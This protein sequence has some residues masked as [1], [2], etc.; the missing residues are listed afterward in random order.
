M[1]KINQGHLTIFCIV[2]VWLGVMDYNPSYN[3]SSWENKHSIH[4]YVTIIWPLITLSLRYFN[5]KF[6][7]LKVES[8]LAKYLHS[9]LVTYFERIK[10]KNLPL[11][12]VHFTK[13]SIT[14]L[15]MPVSYFVSCL[16]WRIHS[17][18][19]SFVVHIWWPNKGCK[20][21][22]KGVFDFVTL[23]L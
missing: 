8:K 18:P 4:D 2:F 14:D 15:W 3:S 9:C 6:V 16:N 17:R 7:Q 22:K 19:K 1:Y 20:S 12:M 13:I 11:K 5:F 21:Y 10:K 23:Y